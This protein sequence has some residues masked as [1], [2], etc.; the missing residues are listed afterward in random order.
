MSTTI[1][2]A[3]ALALCFQASSALEIVNKLLS[4]RDNYPEKLNEC[5]VSAILSIRPQIASGIPELNLPPL[6]PHSLEPIEFVQGDGPVNVRA[7]YDQLV[8]SGFSQLDIKYFDWHFTDLKFFMGATIPSLLIK[9]RYNITG[10]IFELPIEGNGAYTSLLKGVVFETKSDLG[11]HP[12]GKMF[13]KNLQLSFKVRD[14]TTKMDNLFAGNSV[15]SETM[16]H[17]LKENDELIFKEI[18]PAME[19]QWGDLLGAILQAL[20]DALP[21]QV[22]MNL[23]N[24]NSQDKHRKRTNEIQAAEARAQG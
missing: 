23:P 17:F 16:H 14:S 12:D 5:F 19:K 21:R 6:D 24:S 10:R 2:V 8:M 4:C 9:G 15:L 18:Q 20:V 13:M 7:Y 11:V 1:T 3:F 22:L